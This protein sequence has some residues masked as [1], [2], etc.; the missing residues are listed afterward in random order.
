MITA[1]AIAFGLMAGLV[2]IP[3]FMIP[4]NSYV[5]MLS[6]LGIVLLLGKVELTM[7]RRTCPKVLDAYILDDDIF[8]FG[9][10]GIAV[11]FMFKPSLIAW[12]NRIT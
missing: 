7:L 3:V 2:F 11:A 8:P 10:L 12:I 4:E 9:S 5:Q 1:L 6:A